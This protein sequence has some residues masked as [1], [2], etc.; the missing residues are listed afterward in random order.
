MEEYTRTLEERLE[1]KTPPLAAELHITLRERRDG[2]VINIVDHS[3][4]YVC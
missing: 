3:S 2:A 1:K 4:I